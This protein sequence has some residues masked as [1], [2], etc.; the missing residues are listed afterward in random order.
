MRE[1]YFCIVVSDEYYIYDKDNMTR[2]VHPHS[3]LEDYE[4]SLNGQEIADELNRLY[5]E[6][7]ELKR[8]LDE[9]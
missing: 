3:R 5:N 9:N 6:N 7:V 2:P 8:R 1:K 4:E